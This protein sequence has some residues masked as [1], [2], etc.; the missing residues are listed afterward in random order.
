V[1]S[2]DYDEGNSIV[3]MAA[4]GDTRLEWKTSRLED[5]D[6]EEVY[7]GQTYLLTGTHLVN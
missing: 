1:T 3:Y 4:Y 2:I 5:T 6:G 7:V